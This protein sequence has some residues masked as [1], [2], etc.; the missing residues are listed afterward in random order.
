MNNKKP[1]KSS[2]VSFCAALLQEAFA[3]HG[4][5]NLSG[6]ADNYR[7]ILAAE[8]DNKDALHLY[9]VL[10]AQQ[11]D[12][13][14]GLFLLCRA[15]IIDPEQKSFHNNLL[16]TISNSGAGKPAP[17][18]GAIRPEQ[19]IA[20]A[21]SIISGAGNTDYALEI[22]ERSAV[23]WPE[24]PEF[25][26]AL[27]RLL[28]LRGDKE[29]ALA[30]YRKLLELNP[31]SHELACGFG[32]LLLETGATKEAF[33]HFQALS[34]RFP[35]HQRIWHGLALSV[36]GASGLEP[37][38]R[39]AVLRKGLDLNSHSP[40][41]FR[42]YFREHLSACKSGTLRHSD[43][44]EK[45]GK[46]NQSVEELGRTLGDELWFPVIQD[47]ADFVSLGFEF[48]AAGLFA[49]AVQLGERVLREA[50]DDEAVF[51]NLGAMYWRMGFLKKAAECFTRVLSI[52]PEQVAALNNAGALLRERGFSQ[53]AV[54]LLKEALRIQPDFAEA[55]YN[56]GL[57]AEE[58][59][60][61]QMALECFAACL[62]YAPDHWKARA[63]YRKILASL[64]RFSELVSEDELL[65]RT[66]IAALKEAN[67]E[68]GEDP[69]SLG[70]RKD[71][72]E[73][74]FQAACRCSE[75]MRFGLSAKSLKGERNKKSAGGL[76]VGFLSCDFREHAQGFILSEILPC[77]KNAELF[78]YSWGD[79]NGV[80]ENSLCRKKLLSG[81]ALLQDIS[82]ISD[83][84]AA[85]M[86][87]GDQLDILVDMKGWTHG[88]R[89]GIAARR[90]AP[91]QMRWLGQPGTSGAAHFDWIIAD[92]IAIPPEQQAFY[93]ETPLYMPNAYFAMSRLELPHCNR[94]EFGLPEDAF[95]MAAFH[96]SWKIT[97]KT[98]DLWLSLMQNIPHALLWL[99]SSNDES[100]RNIKDF[101]EKKGIASSRLV[102]A[103]KKDRFDHLRRLQLADIALDA[104]PCNGIITTADAL[105]A[106]LPVLT[107]CGRHFPARA[108]A[109]VLKAADL[110]SCIFKDGGSLLSF[111]RRLA[112]EKQMLTDIKAELQNSTAPFFA[113]QSFADILM[114]KFSAVIY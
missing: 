56:M 35:E 75:K 54:F 51:L 7:K 86:I 105:L 94:T 58:Q 76:R 45:D 106:C 10:C 59:N 28:I 101:A 77:L 47:W 80:P 15:L 95:V 71:D 108:A 78:L 64:C 68:I 33:S 37:S 50:P 17:V 72:P 81:G 48:L 65:D 98:L 4:A 73:L 109:S 13:V 18:A 12:Y 23:K 26:Q 49:A 62:K 113:V 111:A 39:L 88:G 96:H 41:L 3:F 2:S 14:Q 67:K 102:F 82:S 92:K 29:K 70:T 60:N 85:G 6:A 114:E 22:L 53:D 20:L 74:V 63:L 61:Q 97:A 42:L 87:S 110:S 57:V 31:E 91:V 90:P 36:H 9:G 107:V 69:F 27:L 38:E 40:D 66:L 19:L 32:F 43:N 100:E 1:Q 55:H 5:G 21:A 79:V 99:M 52:N 11:N 25:Q 83:E 44:A 34:L 16:L 84:E 30:P 24:N 46:S 112:T 104:S 8:P 93:T 103:P 89:P